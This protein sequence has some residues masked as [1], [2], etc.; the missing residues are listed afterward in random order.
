MCVFSPQ[1][2]WSVLVRVRRPGDSAWPPSLPSSLAQRFSVFST[3][4]KN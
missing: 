4:V 2:K 1:E 3:S